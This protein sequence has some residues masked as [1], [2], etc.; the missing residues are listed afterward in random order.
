[1]LSWFMTF[2]LAGALFYKLRA[3]TTRGLLAIAAGS[4]ALVA[5]HWLQVEYGFLA[6][7]RDCTLAMKLALNPEPCGRG[8]VAAYGLVLYGAAAVI[9]AHFGLHAP[10]R[11]SRNKSRN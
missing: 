2:L 4:G 9:A 1:M 3:A 6:P 10:R 11:Q 8:V 5:L 7:T